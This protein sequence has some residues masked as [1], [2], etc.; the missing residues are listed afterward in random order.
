[1]VDIK[2]CP[3][4]AAHEQHPWAEE[5]TMVGGPGRIRDRSRTVL[6]H[7]DGRERDLAPEGKT[8]AL[9]FVEYRDLTRLTFEFET[10]EKIPTRF[11]FADLL[12]GDSRVGVTVVDGDD[13]WA[14]VDIRI[15]ARK[16]F[17]VTEVDA[18]ED[19]RRL[20]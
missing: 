13:R 15:L 19:A 3:R 20:F 4:S 16:P 8:E 18:E 12:P 17:K 6:H 7:C 5:V 11:D 1:M 14:V 10:R 9:G 2:Q